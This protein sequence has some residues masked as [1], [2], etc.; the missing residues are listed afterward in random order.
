MSNAQPAVPEVER[1]SWAEVCARYRDQWVVVVDAIWSDDSF[2]FANGVVLAVGATRAEA[3]GEATEALKRYQGFG[4][5]LA[6]EIHALV[7]RAFPR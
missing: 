2:D 1:F 5:F 6:G 3:M 7:P 4:C